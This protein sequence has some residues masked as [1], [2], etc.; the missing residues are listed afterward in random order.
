MCS[1]LGGGNG[2]KHERRRDAYVST[3]IFTYACVLLP[4]RLVHRRA[5][6]TV[7]HLF[8]WLAELAFAAF[9]RPTYR[10]PVGGAGATP[11]VRSPAPRASAFTNPLPCS[12]SVS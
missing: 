1:G 9:W 4:C 12:A 3:P 10:V 2:G 5:R 8:A 6:A 11:P 7:S